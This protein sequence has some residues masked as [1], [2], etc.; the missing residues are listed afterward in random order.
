MMDIILK[1]LETPQNQKIW[2]LNLTNFENEM[3]NK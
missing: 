2:Q 3:A 1:T